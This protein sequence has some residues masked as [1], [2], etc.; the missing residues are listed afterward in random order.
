M[1]TLLFITLL[2]FGLVISG[3]A[4]AVRLFQKEWSGIHGHENACLSLSS[5]SIL[6]AVC[7]LGLL[8]RVWVVPHIQHVYYDEVYYLS[9]AENILYQGNAAVPL[10]GSGVLPEISEDSFRAAGF[11]VLLAFGA[12]L[13]G[14]ME[15][16]G[17]FV[18]IVLAVLSIAAAYRIVRQWTAD[19][20]LAGWAAFFWAILPVSIKYSTCAAADVSAA[21]LFLLSLMFLGD[22][23]HRRE[24]LFFYTA[25]FAGAYSACIKPIYGLFCLGSLWVAFQM[26]FAR[27]GLKEEVRA[28]RDRILFDAALIIVP[29]ALILVQ[30]ALR[31]VKNS[32]TQFYSQQLILKNLWQNVGY[33]FSPEQGNWAISVLFAVGAGRVILGKETGVA[34]WVLICF[35][36][37][38]GMISGFYLG[39]MCYRASTDSE[40]YFMLIAF[41]FVWLAA[42]GARRI[43]K[44]MRCRS[45]G[46]VAISCAVIFGSG[47][48]LPH[49]I[50]NTVQRK[51]YR[52]VTLLPKVLAFVPDDAY[53]IHEN[54]SSI[55]TQG[56]K[57]AIAVE[58]FLYKDRPRRVANLR[59]IGWYT[60]SEK[61][62][63][64]Q[65]V[66]EREYRCGAEVSTGLIGTRGEVAVSVC[67]RR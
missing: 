21:A 64:A 54:I 22:W 36:T 9:Q 12:L 39:N 63:M 62:L 17:P 11:P 40:R 2:L 19:G 10:K 45:W 49:L 44:S 23:I 26:L 43:M 53:V 55:T 1:M 25:L 66:L 28:Q 29:L 7:V 6:L 51:I 31:E 60:Q 8:L 38:Y 33:L 16:A 46:L 14:D 58:L 30:C 47:Y 18:N 24:R 37:G 32:Y 35:V 65:T 4:A 42:L 15:R 13:A 48:A 3:I 27:P 56:L 67:E 20:A 61:M 50:A 5:G 59:G 41:P 34:R 52:D 57:K